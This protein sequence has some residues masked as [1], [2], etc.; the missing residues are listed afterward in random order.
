V[1]PTCSV[2]QFSVPLL[3]TVGKS[4][5]IQDCGRN[6]YVTEV[7]PCVRRVRPQAP[8]VPRHPAYLLLP[9]QRARG[10]LAPD[11]PPR[12]EQI[13]PSGPRK[14]R[15]IPVDSGLLGLGRA[16]GGMCMVGCSYLLLDR[17]RGVI[18]DSKVVQ[19]LLCLVPD[20]LVG[21]LQ[22]LDQCAHRAAC[23]RAFLNGQES[24]C[25][26][27]RAR[28]CNTHRPPRA[29]R[30]YHPALRGRRASLPA[31]S[32][33][34]AGGTHSWDLAC[35]IIAWESCRLEEREHALR[36]AYAAHSCTDATL[37][38]SSLTSRSAAPQSLRR[39]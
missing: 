33:A 22:H 7:A 20:V 34:A 14:R 12:S 11:L 9:H 23:V 18:V 10:L 3:K 26:C 37:D 15:E 24:V 21:Q 4:Q 1:F 8:V 36:S 30:A 27:A 17:P 29:S 31:W 5:S 38:P 19:R 16:G 13:A 2:A 35:S 6:T 28:A 25:V 32:L 39:A